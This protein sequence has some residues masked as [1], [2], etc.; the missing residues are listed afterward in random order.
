[1]T[2]TIGRR[3]LLPIVTGGLVLLSQLG[4]PVNA[5]GA[6]FNVSKFAS[7][8]ALYTG[9]DS[10]DV[11]GDR[12]FVGFTNNTATDGSDG[13]TSTIVQ[14]T[15]D[16]TV[17][18]TFAVFGHNDG[19]RVN[20]ADGLVWAIQNEDGNPN[21]AIINPDN[22]AI[23]TF[24]LPA[25]HGGGYDD[26]TFIDDQA[27][28]S[29]S[30]PTLDANGVNTFP[31]IVTVEISGK[32]VTLTPV[33]MGNAPGFNAVTGAPLTLNLID[34]DSLTK[35]PS[36]GLVLSNQAANQVILID[37]PGTPRQTAS[38]L[39]VTSPTGTSLSVDD[40][41]FPKSRRGFLLVTD[42]SAGVI[43]KVQ[44]D[45]PL[46]RGT[47]FSAALNAGILGELDLESGVLTPVVTVIAAPR[48]L[49]FLNGEDDEEDFDGE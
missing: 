37:K 40:T 25:P 19:L 3:F 6:D 18:Q 1:M 9:P 14:Y 12:V 26:V 45:S 38:V 15:T 47:V 16:G 33:L 10:I 24:K 41:L 31:A 7:S 22:G 27:F 46:K 23:A 28:I 11:A 30:S 43:Y 42:Q 20:P 49:A 34:P 5:L 29:A 44:S 13:K 36:G 8:T 17:V 21:L 48:G 35:T 39:P 2:R 32:T 4:T